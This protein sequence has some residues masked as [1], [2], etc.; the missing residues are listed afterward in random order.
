[1]KVISI[2]PSEIE[3]ECTIYADDSPVYYRYDYS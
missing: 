1:M 2:D 3:K